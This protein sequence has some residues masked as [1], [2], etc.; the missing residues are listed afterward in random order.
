MVN[1][2]S[3]PDQ[4]RIQ[5]RDTIV[6][7]VIAIAN[8]LRQLVDEDFASDY[9]PSTAES[10]WNMYGNTTDLTQHLQSKI[11]T[12]ITKKA[13]LNSQLLIAGLPRDDIRNQHISAALLSASHPAAKL[14]LTTVPEEPVLTLSNA[15]VRAM[16]QHRIAT[17]PP[18]NAAPL[19]CRCGT[20]AI[21][22]TQHPHVCT[23]IRKNSGYRRHELIVAGIQRVIRAAGAI[24]SRNPP[25]NF[26][27]NPNEAALIPDLFIH[28]LDG[29]KYM[30]DISII[31]P[32]AASHRENAS[33]RRCAAA[34]KRE[35]EKVNKY[36]ALALRNNFIFIP[37]VIETYGA[38]GEKAE[39]FIKEIAECCN[40]K[41]MG[42]Y[43]KRVIAIALQ[44]GNAMVAHEGA[45]LFTH[46]RDS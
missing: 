24:V 9:L 33:I 22:D 1:N 35:N 16:I 6:L 8:D 26:L 36:S 4:Y 32:N 2:N 31:Y 43:C 18:A 42:A 45:Y 5:T 20:L 34:L 19:Q 30:L 14:C 7:E 37:I 10:L 40:D 28:T 25:I 44:R 21:Y 46:I 17:L 11:T 27:R 23:L 39:L 41:G 29:R 12:A 3:I 13:G 15:E 38:M